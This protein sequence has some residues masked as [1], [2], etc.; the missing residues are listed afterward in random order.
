MKKLAGESDEIITVV[1]KRG[2]RNV[3][4]ILLRDRG[5]VKAPR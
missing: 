3:Q 5:D 2:V 1:R 4:A